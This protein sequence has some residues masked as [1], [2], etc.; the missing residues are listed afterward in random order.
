MTHQNITTKPGHIS[1]LH[2]SAAEGS[3]LQR[4]KEFSFASFVLVF[5]RRPPPHDLEQSPKV[6]ALQLQSTVRKRE[7]DQIIAF[8]D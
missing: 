8:Y 6:Q 4:P 1:V 3:P 7:S 5:V 2:D